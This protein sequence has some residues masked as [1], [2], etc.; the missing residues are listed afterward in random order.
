MVSMLA[1]YVEILYT[2]VYRSNFKDLIFRP[3][4]YVSLHMSDNFFKVE[5]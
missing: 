1:K 3:K 4:I 5:I 2:F